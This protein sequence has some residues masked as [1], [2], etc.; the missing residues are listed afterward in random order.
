MLRKKL[1]PSDLV[2]QGLTLQSRCPWAGIVRSKGIPLF[3]SFFSTDFQLERRES[4]VRHLDFRTT[5]FYLVAVLKKF[6][7]YGKIRAV[8]KPSAQYIERGE[9]RL[10]DAV[11]EYERG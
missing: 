6:S 9:R 11:M 10:I 4:P 3:S 7:R 2:Q 5:A 1:I 8:I